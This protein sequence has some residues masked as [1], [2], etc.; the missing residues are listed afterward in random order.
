MQTITLV[1]SSFLTVHSA[2]VAH[3]SIRKQG[4]KQSLPKQASLLGQSASDLHV[5]SSTIGAGTRGVMV[6]FIWL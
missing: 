6:I 2:F 1:G 3:G 5:A 4:S